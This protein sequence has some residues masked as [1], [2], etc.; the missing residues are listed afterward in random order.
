MLELADGRIAELT[1]FLDTETL[2]PLFGLPPR[3]EPITPE[4][5]VEP[6]ERDELAQL[7]R[8]VPQ[9][10]LAAV[11]P[12]AS[13]SRASASTVTASRIDATTSQKR[14]AGAARCE[15]PQT[16]SQSPA[17]RPARS[18]RG[19]ANAIVCGARRHRKIDR[20]DRAE[21][22]GPRADEFRPRTPV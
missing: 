21:L 7:G 11:A 20:S 5:V 16:R 18:D 13:C 1:F 4:H 12:A 15:Q 9:P 17:G 8:R 22:I 2:F 19:S 14:D 10:H 3:L 6:H